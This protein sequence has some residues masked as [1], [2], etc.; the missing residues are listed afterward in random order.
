[1]H[2]VVDNVQAVD[3]RLLSP[4]PPQQHTYEAMSSYT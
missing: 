4:F 2:S 1:M 3:T